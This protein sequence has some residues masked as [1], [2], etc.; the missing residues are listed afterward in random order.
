MRRGG[1]GVLANDHMTE[2][3]GKEPTNDLAGH[4]Y[5]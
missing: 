4:A 3:L 2:G 1:G 5:G